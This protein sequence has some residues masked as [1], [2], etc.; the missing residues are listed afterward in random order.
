MTLRQALMQMRSKAF[1]ARNLFLAVDTSWRKTSTP[2]VT[3]LFKKDLAAKVNSMLPALPLVLQAKFGAEIWNWFKDDARENT[4]GYWWDP[5]RGV[6]AQGDDEQD[7]WGDSLDSDNEETGYW[8]STSTA[9]GL[10][11]ASTRSRIEIEPFS[12]DP[13]SG[14]N[15]YDLTGKDGDDKSIGDYSTITTKGKIPS[16]ES[17]PKLKSAMRTGSVETSTTSLV[18]TL[19]PADSTSAHD[20]ILQ[21]M[22]DDP[23][24]A[25]AMMAQFSATKPASGLSP[26][27]TPNDTT[28]TS[29]PR[30]EGK[31][32]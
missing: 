19:S 10:S 3:F 21:R 4:A 7:S 12:I 23:A 16:P 22:R 26:P 27:G 18:S 32:E 8:S 13:T 6:R 11:R 31:G 30:A 15:E 5:K 28:M 2:F 1:P 20:A 29:P 14:K 9:S 25:T 17:P 24:Y